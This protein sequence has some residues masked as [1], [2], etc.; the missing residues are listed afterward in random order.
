MIMIIYSSLIFSD[1]FMKKNSKKNSKENSKE[2]SKKNSKKLLIN[3]IF[4]VEN[5]MCLYL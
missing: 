5:Y 4:S 2:N 3:N 1:L